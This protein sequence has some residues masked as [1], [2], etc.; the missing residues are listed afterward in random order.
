[1]KQ[2]FLKI[3][4]LFLVFITF[5]FCI[6]P[7]YKFLEV[8][9][10]FPYINF[11][12]IR[13]SMFGLLIFILFYIYINKSKIKIDIPFLFFYLTVSLIVIFNF[14][15]YFQDKI[16]SEAY[17]NRIDSVIIMYPLMYLCGYYYNESWSKL[18]H[19]LFLVFSVFLL[20][21]SS[22]LIDS[23]IRFTIEEPINYIK[24]SDSYM[25]LALLNFKKSRVIF[26]C[27]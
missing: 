27:I 4:I 23:F 24:I 12:I 22:L 5:H 15:L 2:R 26:Y 6:L 17:L 11:G 9:F 25:F 7:I 13:T 19:K 14:D 18:I 20:L 10:S 1:M 16:H 3:D 21:N 8:Y